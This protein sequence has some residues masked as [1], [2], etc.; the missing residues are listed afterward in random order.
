VGL[1]GAEGLQELDG[2]RIGF[3]FDN[4]IEEPG[5]VEVIDRLGF[6]EGRNSTHMKACRGQRGDSRFEVRGTIA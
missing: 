5:L 2:P 1:D 4:A 3:T 6:V